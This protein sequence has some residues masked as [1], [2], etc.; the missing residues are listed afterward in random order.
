[1]NFDG[2]ELEK[3]QVVVKN[4]EEANGLMR[5]NVAM[6]SG[7]DNGL[8]QKV[9]KAMTTAAGVTAGAVTLVTA[10]R[11]FLHTDKSTNTQKLQFM[12]ECTNLESV[13]GEGN[14]AAKLTK[15]E[16]DTSVT[17]TGSFNEHTT[18]DNFYFS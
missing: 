8:P 14:Y 12:A 7:V 11:Y 18:F 10:D 16:S 3:S 15:S 6:G 5:T 17:L 2:N 1:L 4:S 9:V 13:A